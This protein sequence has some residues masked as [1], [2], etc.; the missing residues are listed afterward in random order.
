MASHASM[1]QIDSLRIDSTHIDKDTSEAKEKI[2]FLDLVKGKPGRAGLY[3][4]LLPGGGQIYNRAWWK[5]PLAIGIDGFTIYYLLDNRSKYT[6]YDSQYK[7]ALADPSLG[8]ASRLRKIRNTYRKRY[9]YG[10]VYLILGRL[11]GVVDAYVDQ[12]FKGFDV[13]DDLSFRIRP[14]HQNM[15]LSLQFSFSSRASTKKHKLI[16]P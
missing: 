12:H 1:G 7:A 6:S 5:V 11:I 8:N 14:S 3:S 16:H 10:W 2:T 4:L 15:G 9:E 13:S